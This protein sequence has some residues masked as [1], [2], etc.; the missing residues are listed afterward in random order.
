MSVSLFLVAFIISLGLTIGLM[1][2]WDRRGGPKCIICGE[3]DKTGEG[4]LECD[5]CGKW[6]CR[7]DLDE[8]SITSPKQKPEPTEEREGH[9]AAVNLYGKELNLCNYCLAR[10]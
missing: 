6:F 10:I 7:T 3:P 5:H 4:H 1:V 8:I 2:W 9:G